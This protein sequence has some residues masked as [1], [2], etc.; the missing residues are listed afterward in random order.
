MIS[1]TQALHQATS[2]VDT[3]L[4]NAINS[5]DTEFGEGYARRHPLL[6][7]SYLETCAK[8][9]ETAIKSGCVDDT[10]NNTLMRKYDNELF[11]NQ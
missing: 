4:S 1:A 8:D 3:Y 10:L 7:V 11:E 2:T 9:Y 6:V 5:I